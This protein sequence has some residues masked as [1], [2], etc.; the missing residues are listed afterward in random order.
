MIWWADPRLIFRCAAV[1]FTV[2]S[3]TVSDIRHCH[4]DIT[5][6]HSDIRWAQQQKVELKMENEKPKDTAMIQFYHTIHNKIHRFLKKRNYQK[7]SHPE[8]E[9]CTVAKVCFRRI[10]TYGPGCV[11]DT[12]EGLLWW[13]AKNTRDTYLCNNLRSPQWQNIAAT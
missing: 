4:S 8:K 9:N 10:T 11:S 7:S 13:S 6:C 3:D 2:T 1:S 5:H 12:A